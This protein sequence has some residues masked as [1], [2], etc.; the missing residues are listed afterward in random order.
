MST[1]VRVHVVMSGIFAFK[2]VFSLLNYDK[3]ITLTIR[4]SKIAYPLVLHV[5]RRKFSIC[6][7]KEILDK[8]SCSSIDILIYLFFV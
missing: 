7:D 4:K 3:I 6:V 8:F 2:L 5:I 1:C